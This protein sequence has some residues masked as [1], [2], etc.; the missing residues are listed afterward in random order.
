[1]MS[2]IMSSQVLWSYQVGSEIFLLDHC[3][4]QQSHSAILVDCS[5]FSKYRSH[6]LSGMEQS[7]GKM[8]YKLTQDKRIVRPV[9]ISTNVYNCSDNFILCNPISDFVKQSFKRLCFLGKY[10]ELL[11]SVH[12]KTLKKRKKKSVS[13]MKGKYWLY[14][15]LNSIINIL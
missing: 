1:M 2:L 15:M 13:L 11:Q 3:F 14:L 5:L 4:S 12:L 9:Y 10:V 6:T 8:T 7:M